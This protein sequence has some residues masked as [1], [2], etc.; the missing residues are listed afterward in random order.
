MAGVD[1]YL[2]ANIP[3][4]LGAGTDQDRV[5]VL[6]A[7]DLRLWESHIRAEA[8]QQ[9]FAQNLSVFV[10]LYNY[11]AFQAARYPQS[12]SVINGTGLNLTV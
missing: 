6:K 12:I 11:I 10:R 5:I 3:T 4:N 9:T 2:D 1:I 8:F 7:D